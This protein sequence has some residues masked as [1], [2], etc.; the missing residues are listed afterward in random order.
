MPY[1]PTK[2][3]KRPH[4]KPTLHSKSRW[5]RASKANRDK[6]VFCEVWLSVGR[7]VAGEVT[8]H[9][10]AVESGGAFWL[11]DNWMVMSHFWHNR[12]TQ[13]E[14]EGLKLDSY[15]AVGGKVPVNRK[16]VIKILT[17]RYQKDIQEWQEGQRL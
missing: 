15:Q 1:V 3:R 10:I 5:R 6:H 17:N 2:Q 8:D 14:K 7:H 12:K 9:I 4:R 11:E 16:Q 13:L